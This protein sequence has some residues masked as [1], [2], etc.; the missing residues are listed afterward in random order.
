MQLLNDAGGPADLHGFGGGDRAQAEMHRPGAGRSVTGG[1][2]DVVIL[3]LAARD[4]LDPCAD[5]VAVALGAL[6]LKLEPVIPV[7]AVV[8]PDLGGRAEGGDDDVEAA[9]AVE[10]T[11]GRTAMA[12]G[13]LP[14]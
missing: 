9:V 2:G 1:E 7:R 11:D 8:D 12:A 5:R 14:R 10:V 13:R 3:R 6:E 4:E